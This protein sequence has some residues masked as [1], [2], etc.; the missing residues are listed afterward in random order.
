MRYW[1][2]LLIYLIEYNLI[3]TKNNKESGIIIRKFYR[4]HLP[5]FFLKLLGEKHFSSH[6]WLIIDFDYIQLIS[7]Y[8]STYM[9]SEDPPIEQK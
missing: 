1:A 5:I 2:N 6:F 3:R 4:N 8:F 9:S 7:K